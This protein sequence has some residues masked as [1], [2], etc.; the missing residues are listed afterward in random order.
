VL[1]FGNSL[2][3]VLEALHRP[4][5]GENA[6]P[7]P[8][9]EILESQLE[10]LL[11]IHWR[12]EGYPDKE[13]EQAALLEAR[14]ILKYYV[15][16]PYVPSGQ[17]L[18]SE[19][20]LNTHMTVASRKLELSARF[21]RVELLPGGVLECLDYKTNRDGQV[22]SPNLLASDLSSFI[23]FLLAW[24]HFRSNPAVESVAIS[25]LNLW[26]LSKSKADFSQRHIVANKEALIQLVAS[27][28]AEEFEPR[29]NRSCAWCPALENC[30]AWLELDLD[31]V[32][33]FGA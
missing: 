6:S 11:T 22:P 8:Q 16:S 14:S 1:S 21:D 32:T 15:R 31:D 28:T 29:T 9:R 5:P 3:A 33:R 4:L 19:L 17:V 27:I 18:G 20:Y 30:P 7:P 10:D 26:S 13:S 23:Y 25:Q 12:S 24:V 2:H